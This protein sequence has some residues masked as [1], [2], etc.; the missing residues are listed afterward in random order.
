MPRFDR[1]DAPDLLAA[2]GSEFWSVD[3]GDI[4]AADVARWLPGNQGDIRAVVSIEP[5]AVGEEHAGMGAWHVNAR[6]ELHLVRS[7]E[8]LL[9][10][11]TDAGV[12]SVW[13]GAGDVMAMRGAEHRFRALTPQEWVLRWSGAPED[14][15]GARTTGRPSEAW[16]S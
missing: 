12:V 11:I 8:G 14:D 7:G 1:A 2:V 4:D 9:Q 15:L 10:V 16:P 3:G 6:H 5:P 13:L